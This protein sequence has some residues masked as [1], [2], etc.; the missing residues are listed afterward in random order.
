MKEGRGKEQYCVMAGLTSDVVT[1][2]C[3][4]SGG[5]QPAL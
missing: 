5:Y 2:K 4:F 1:T 3:I